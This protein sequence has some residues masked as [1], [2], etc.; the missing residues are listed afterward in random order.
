MDLFEK[1]LNQMPFEFTSNQFMKQAKKNGL[2]IRRLAEVIKPYA[3]NKY[4]ASKTYVKKQKYH[5]TNTKLTEQQMI[6][7]LKEKGYRIMKP[8]NDWVEI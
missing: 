2:Y 1:T 8:V 6:N 5:L 4:P 7:A 3:E